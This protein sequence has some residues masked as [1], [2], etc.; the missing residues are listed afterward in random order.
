M[1][2]EIHEGIPVPATQRRSRASAYG[3]LTEMVD[4]ECFDIPVP[5]QEPRTT[6]K[7]KELSAEQAR[8]ALAHGRQSYIANLAK[9]KG[10]KVITRWLPEGDEHSNDEPVVRVWFDGLIEDEPELDTSDDE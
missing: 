10:V 5:E 1:T 6:R 8:E 9:K 3:V 7:G 4:G 2:F